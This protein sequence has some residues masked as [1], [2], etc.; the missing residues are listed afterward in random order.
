MD[1]G[2]IAMIQTEKLVSTFGVES[3]LKLEPHPQEP[4]ALALLSLNPGSI[5]SSEK[6]MVRPSR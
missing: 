3:V 2:V 5:R 1:I 6:S 4:L